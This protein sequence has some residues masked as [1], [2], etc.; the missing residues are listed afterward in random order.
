[1]ITEA[2]HQLI[3]RH[4]LLQKND[5]VIVA[6]SGGPDSLALLHLLWAMR[7]RYT[8]QVHACHLNHQLRGEEADADAQYV[9]T[10][11]EKRKIPFYIKNIDVDKVAKERNC[12]IQIAARSVRYAWFS[13]LLRE[14]G[15]E[16]IATGHHGDDQ[17]E[18]IVMET[19]RGNNPLKP[20]GIPVKRFVEG[21]AIIRP[22]LT[23]TKA[24]IEKYCEKMAL[25]PRYDAS[26]ESLKYTRNRVR[27]TIIPAMK[28]ENKTAHVH[29]QRQHEWSHDDHHFL[30]SIAK[31]LLPTI[32]VN[33]SE[34]MITISR[35]AFL[36]VVL[37]LQR[38]MIHLLLSYLCGK[39]SR[40]SSIHIEDV[41]E[42]ISSDHPSAQYQL[43]HS[44]YVRREY[45]V[46]HF[47]IAEEKKIHT[48]FHTVLPIPGHIKVGEWT[49]TSTVET[50]EHVV[51][52]ENQIVLNMEKI[53]EPLTIRSW[54]AGDKIACRGMT[55]SKNV[56]RLFI[57][58]KVAK[59]KRA[60]WP[61]LVDYNDTILWAPFLHRTRHFYADSYTKKRLVVSCFCKSMNTPV[62]K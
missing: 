13:K 24:E 56:A 5:T 48:S 14:T 58:R 21:G 6:V 3:T 30:Q 19:V 47:S 35:L 28:A 40:L 27:Q 57:D 23:V 11:C 18:T 42:L 34:R 15:A 16:K 46:C 51:E 53:V 41:I 29:M 25:K 36:N 37:P 12:S 60:Q 20:F 9:R 49:F 43:F 2:V 45:E 61:L 8:I 1:M 17:M 59:E 4:R 44:I 54:I 52:K 55:G 31:Q 50:D 62:D 26:N 33:K 32:I 22:L 39:N 38:R 10:F 7:D